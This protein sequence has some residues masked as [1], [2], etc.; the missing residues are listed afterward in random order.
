MKVARIGRIGIASVLCLTLCLAVMAA[1]WP[2]QTAAAYDSFYQQV[3]GF[4]DSVFTSLDY[5]L[6]WYDADS[7]IPK[8]AGTEGA[9]FDP[10]KPTLIFTH[11]MKITEGYGRRDLVSLW[12]GTNGEFKNKGY[13]PYMYSDQYYQILL[14]MGYNV[15]HF[16]WNQLAEISID[17]DF[18]VWTSDIYDADG[19]DIGLNYYVSNSKGRR[20]Q[21]DPAQN[22]HDSVA[23]LFGEA[24]KDGLGED[25]S[26]P[27]RLVGHSMGGQLV[28]ATT[29]NLIYQNEQGTIGDNLLPE[30]VSLI[31]PYMCNTKTVKGMR[32]DHMGGKEIPAGTWTAEL[33]ADAMEDI[34]ARDI[35][36][37]AYGGAVMVYRNYMAM[38]ET[39]ISG[40]EYRIEMAENLGEDEESIAELRADLE[41]LLP[42]RDRY[43][44]L[45]Q[46]IGNAACWT[47]LD[48]LAD[49]TY[50]AVSHCMIIDYFFTT[51]YEDAQTDNYGKELPSLDSTTDYIRSLRGYNFLQVKRAGSTE[52]PFYR[53][54]TDF[55]RVDAYRNRITNI[56]TGNALGYTTAELVND[57]GEVVQTTAV[58]ES[59]A[60]YFYSVD[61]GAYTVRCISDAAT[62]TASLTV[63]AADEGTSISVAAPVPA[64]S[65]TGSDIA[66][67]IYILIAPAVLLLV[68]IVVI[69]VCALAIK[70]AKAAV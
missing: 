69:V 46:R 65:E 19:N 53:H 41:A 26:Q 5:G 67:L 32:L 37:D 9:N 13:D 31:D 56:V 22:P 40:A 45:T 12:S 47:H 23:V 60:Y 55:V 68:M 17:E 8:K 14:D 15:G 66:T 49:Q 58:A 59:G 21:G 64:E 6:Y 16:Y 7:R 30:R 52:N 33:C 4:D 51:M 28:L 35:A 38:I 54:T 2:T 57:K 1:F 62:A 20:T 18:H 10:N 43:T 50:G 63:R 11:G 29:Q 44:A 61:E 27:W 25:Y 3:P 36:I 24:I 34:A 42:E 48:A 70:K 39:D